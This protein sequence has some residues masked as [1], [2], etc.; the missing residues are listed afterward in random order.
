MMG[1]ELDRAAIGEIENNFGRDLIFAHS[2]TA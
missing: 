1:R 2:H